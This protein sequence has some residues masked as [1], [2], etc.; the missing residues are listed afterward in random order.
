MLMATCVAF[1]M[2]FA[3]VGYAYTAISVNDGN[4]ASANYVT[5]TQEGSDIGAYT[6]GDA[7]IR[8]D[9]ISTRYVE[10]WYRL[11]DSVD[12]QVGSDLYKGAPPTRSRP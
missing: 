6:F 2:M 10:T 8:Y 5:I 7:E 4:N 12:I 1:M 3:G 11:L 9:L